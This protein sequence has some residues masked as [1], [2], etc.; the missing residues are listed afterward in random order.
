MKKNS[1]HEVCP[2]T[3]MQHGTHSHAEARVRKGANRGKKDA[4]SDSRCGN[5]CQGP[6]HRK[7]RGEGSR[8]GGEP[9]RAAQKWRLWK[10]SP[11]SWEAAQ[12]LDLDE[13]AKVSTD[14]NGTIV[15]RSY[16]TV[17]L[18][19]RVATSLSSTGTC[20]ARVSKRDTH[21]KAE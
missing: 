13:L 18:Q 7:S 2:V 3:R 21:G 15:T 16:Q 5:L 10:K 14:C 9:S 4:L 19:E 1:G 12:V 11:S 17:V 6:R 20:L 8:G